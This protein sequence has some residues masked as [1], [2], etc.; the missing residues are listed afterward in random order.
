ML[1][2][3]LT[4]I[5]KF[6]RRDLVPQD[7][8]ER[9]AAETNGIGP[10][11]GGEYVCQNIGMAYR[12]FHTTP[13]S[14]F[15]QQPFTGDGV[16]LTWDGRLDNREEIQAQ[17]PRR[18]LSKTP[19]DIELVFAAYHKWGVGCFSELIGDWALAVWDSRIQQLILARDYIGV[20]RLFYRQD[21]NGVVWCTILEP[22][23][24]TAPAKL[25][26]DL[27][28]LA[29]CL[30]PR[31]PIET[32][33][34]QE[35]RAVVPGTFITIDPQRRR[36][37]KRYWDLSPNDR[38]RHKSDAEYEEHFRDVFALAVRRRLRSDKTI[39]AEL[40]G[41]VDSS[42]I[43]CMADDL[44]VKESGPAIETLSYYDPAEPSGDERPYFSLIEQRRGKIGHH[45]SLADFETQY[46]QEALAPLPP[47]RSV[48]SPGYFR[49]AL[50]WDQTLHDIHTTSDTRVVL[51][52]VGGDELLGGIQ[53]ASPE[54]AD[55]LLHGRLVTF[56]RSLM[57]WSV[58]RRRPM[59]HLISE[60]A[61]LLKALRRP[62]R[63]GSSRTLAIPW[64]RVCPPKRHAA[65]GSFAHWRALPPA[66]LNME[67]VRYDLGS[68]LTSIDFPFVGCA[69]RRYPF[70]DR[71]L[72]VFLASIPRTQI[73][74]ARHR[75]HLM[76]RA[77]RET[78]PHGVLFRKT[79]WFGS[80]GPLSLFQNHAGL[81]DQLFG[82]SWL[83]HGLIVDITMLRDVIG[84]MQQGASNEGL[85]LRA[86]IGIEYW[87]R[88]VVDAG[89]IEF[90]SPAT[91]MPI[92]P[93]P[94]A[95]SI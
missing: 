21:P 4:G 22:L 17:V 51:S 40:S 89:S 78:V 75:R 93:A 11:G 66:K 25:H 62:N 80:R 58:A 49:S 16:V 43:V 77:L 95:A 18:Y 36:S 44:R 90:D 79:K 30:Y 10:D 38:I 53:Y 84:R 32:T 41:G 9:L 76:R 83:S 91:A 27:E 82:D 33:P 5:F 72:F 81:L 45:I 13:E 74:Q 94:S 15:E 7:E 14:H 52:G 20:R 37:T 56:A 6:D 31:P 60:T 12:A 28:Y 47:Y 92:P 29:G 69:E 3:A 68:Q 19:T 88:S 39:L 59:L 86:A 50:R 2:S 54:L 34:Y 61:E 1:M 87:L 65:F 64:V 73:L 71:S 70:L 23:V 42:S 48:A 57:E 24:W 85:Q 26:L 8:M 67:R 55:Y 46:S 63:A 35:I